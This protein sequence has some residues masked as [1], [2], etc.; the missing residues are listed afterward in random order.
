MSLSKN[1]FIPDWTR[2][3]CCVS[4][5]NAYVILPSRSLG[6]A[7]VLHTLHTTLENT[8]QRVPGWFHCLHTLLSSSSS[9]SSW[10]CI[11]RIGKKKRVTL[12]MTAGEDRH[13]TLRWDE[14]SSQALPPSSLT[15]WSTVGNPK[16]QS[17]LSSLH[18]SHPSPS[19]PPSLPPPLS[20]SLPLSLH[21]LHS[22]KWA[23]RRFAAA[24]LGSNVPKSSWR[25][26]YICRRR[27]A[28]RLSSSSARKSIL[29]SCLE[30]W[31]GV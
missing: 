2:H 15:L 5:K 12:C 9:S 17:R 23:A 26:N 28:A 30:N 11:C 24:A 21:P 29:D 31:T 13:L 19:F 27:L 6:R 22:W 4:I 25:G 7:A 14:I 3:I 18:S 8:F 10:F 16:L 1:K 20:S